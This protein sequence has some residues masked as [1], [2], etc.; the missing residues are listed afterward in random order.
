MVIQ[1]NPDW[2]PTLKMGY[3]KNR[4]KATTPNLQRYKR[5]EK[6]TLLKPTKLFEESPFNNLYDGHNEDETYEVINDETGISCNIN[7]TMDNISELELLKD[8]CD[9]LQGDVNFF[10]FS[11][12]SFLGRPTMFTYYAGLTM[13]VFKLILESIKPGLTAS[14]QRQF[15][16]LLLCLMKLKLNLPF[17]D[18]GFR[19]NITCATASMIFRKVIILLEHMFKRLIYWPDR[20]ALISTMP[21][22]FFNVFG[23]S[24]AVILGCFEITI[25][26][27]S[28]L[29]A[30]AQSWSSYKNKNTV[31]Y[32]IAIRPQGNISFISEGWGGRTSDKYITKNSNLLNK[33]LP[34]DVV[35]LY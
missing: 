7:L 22:S 30:R 14:N 24:V 6:R 9:Q 26:K 21:Q 32:L 13:D 27:P 16:K 15:Q 18:L 34:G 17:K 20:E 23:N 28:N 2:T 8:K 3:T 12:N 19:F 1:K 11:E 10:N 4:G 33:L 35:M 31:K 5:S 29:K 25:E